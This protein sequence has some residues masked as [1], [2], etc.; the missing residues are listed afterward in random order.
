MRELVGA[1]DALGAGPAS[2]QGSIFNIGSRLSDRG[3]VRKLAEGGLV[4]V[5]RDQAPVINAQYV[6]GSAEVFQSAELAARRR[7]IIL[8]LLRSNSRMGLR[9][10]EISAALERGPALGTSVTTD[11]IKI[12]MEQLSREKKAARLPGSRRW[13][14]ANDPRLTDPLPRQM[15]LNEAE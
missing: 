9:N 2:N 8:D 6:W 4:L 10:V 14:L 5:N 7:E 13:V 3:V 12:D 11:V 15:L 1:I